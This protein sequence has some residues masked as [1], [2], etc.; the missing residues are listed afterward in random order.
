MAIYTAKGLQIVPD[1]LTSVKE[2]TLKD[3]SEAGKIVIFFGAGVS[4]EERFP[5][6]QTLN[7]QFIRSLEN[8]SFVDPHAARG[9]TLLYPERPDDVLDT[10]LRKSKASIIDEYKKIFSPDRSKYHPTEIGKA[11]CKLKVDRFVTPNYDFC[12]HNSLRASGITNFTEINLKNLDIGKFCTP[13]EII[14]SQIHGTAEDHIDDIVLT[15]SQYTKTYVPHGPLD[16]FLRY[17]FSEYSIIFVGVGFR[18][19][20]IMSI[21][22]DLTGGGVRRNNYDRIAFNGHEKTPDEVDKSRAFQIVAKEQWDIDVLDYEI[23]STRT[24]VDHSNI[25]NL[26]SYVGDIIGWRSI[27]TTL[28]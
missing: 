17:V 23:L 14:V 3:A 19:R 24:F 18:D 6:G 27:G 1:R 25:N 7:E 12:F 10:T 5:D 13:N 16:Q 11:L 26:I 15:S 9:F 4:I 22:K 28:P 2:Q 20:E 21:L 8:D